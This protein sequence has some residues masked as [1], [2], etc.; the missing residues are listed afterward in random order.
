MFMH[1]KNTLSLTMTFLQ[2]IF[3]TSYW[4]APQVEQRSGSHSRTAR[5]QGHCFVVHWALHLSYATTVKVLYN[6]LLINT[7]AYEDS[8]PLVNTAVPIYFER[9]KFNI[10]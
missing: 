1:E 2:E 5:K 4:S 7:K 6:R 10:P 3:E 9:A 8:I